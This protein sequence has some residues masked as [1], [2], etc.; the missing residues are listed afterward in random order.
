MALQEALVRA[1]Q[2]LKGDLR[3]FPEARARIE[4][5]AAGTGGHM[6][7]NGNQRRTSSSR[8]PTAQKELGIGTTDL[9]RQLLPLVRR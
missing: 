7:R 9:L 8:G 5:C 3:I 6:L 2:D 1:V 4:V